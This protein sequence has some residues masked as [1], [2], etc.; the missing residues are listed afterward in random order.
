MSESKSIMKFGYGLSEQDLIDLE[1]IENEERCHEIAVEI[2]TI[3]KNTMREMIYASCEIGRLLCE[4]KEKLPHGA[5]G[6]WLS[7]NFDYSQSTANNL[8]RLHKAY[9]QPD[10][11]DMFFSSEERMQIFGKLTP[12]QA[13]ALLPLPEPERI[14]FVQSHDMDK[15]S[16]R[17]IEKEIKAREDAEKRAELAE[18]EQK[19]LE[20]ELDERAREDREIKL[21]AD[22]LRSE[23]DSIKKQKEA[24]AAALSASEKKA[25]KEKLQKEFDKK[26]EAEKKAL[27]LKLTEE[28]K[29]NGELEASLENAKK[30][31]SEALEKEYVK[32]LLEADERVR[33]AEKKAQ[34][35]SNAS[36]QRFS[37]LFEQLQS[38][39]SA[40]SRLL[41]DIKADE[42]ELAAK[43]VTS[44]RG[45]LEKMVGGL[46]P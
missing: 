7:E 38:T 39:Y 43:L 13:L 3:R 24:K 15:T 9:G 12:S 29:K 46:V 41:G 30:E 16:V 6:A 36:V 35:A 8:M 18:K 40:M 2:N 42:P 34:N 27:S 5:W 45:I 14:E 19:K 28:Q 32:R 25:I 33:A 11:L 37:V 4:A 10:Q 21:E 1:E 17:D 31:A 26:L 23:L 22:K 44:L 20:E